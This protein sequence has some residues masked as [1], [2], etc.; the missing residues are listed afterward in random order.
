MPKAP[1]A[2]RMSCVKVDIGIT[3]L[4]PFPLSETV[5]E[6]LFVG[7]MVQVG[8][9]LQYGSQP[10]PGSQ[11]QTARGRATDVRH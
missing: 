5:R 3:Y 7:D 11:F 8:D 4:L 9:E 10:N 2:T 6:S 1:A